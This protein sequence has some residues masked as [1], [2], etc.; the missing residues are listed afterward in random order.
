[1]MKNA[2]CDAFTESIVAIQLLHEICYKTQ[3][4]KSSYVP[5]GAP[6][7]F[8]SSKYQSRYNRTT[9]LAKGLKGISCR[10]IIQLRYLKYTQQLNTL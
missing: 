8:P 6:Y 7:E 4:V 3:G 5:L 2:K 9:H 10:L 1:M